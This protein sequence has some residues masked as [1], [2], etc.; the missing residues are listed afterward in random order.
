MKTELEKLE[1]EINRKKQRTVDLDIIQRSLQDFSRLIEVLPLEDQKELMQ[2]L[3]EEIVVW[4]YDP[5]RHKAP[6][7]EGTFT[8]KI[9]TK[10]YKV[11]IKL[12]QI[13]ELAGVVNHS[14]ESS[15]KEGLGSP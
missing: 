14:A 4:P 2:L 13:P 5:E 7:E 8:A 3:I 9:R 12:H 6:S 10:Y 15:D 11:D 1:I